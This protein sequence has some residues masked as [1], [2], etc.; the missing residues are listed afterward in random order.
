MDTKSLLLKIKIIPTALAI[1]L[2]LMEIVVYLDKTDVQPMW[3]HD[4]GNIIL[5]FIAIFTVSA[6]FIGKRSAG[7]R[8]QSVKPDA[9]LPAKLSTY[10]GAL[11][12][13]LAPL[14]GVGLISCV[15]YRLSHQ[16]YFLTFPTLIAAWLLIQTFSTNRM[17]M[18][19]SLSKQERDELNI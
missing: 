13:S 8:L 6:I 2:I 12:V 18:D 14:E 19:L 15:L 5:A 4:S 9:A 16:V 10:L 1:G 3:A 11:V 7:A 17:I